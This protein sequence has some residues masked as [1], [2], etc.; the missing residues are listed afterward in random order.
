MPEGG[1][2][3]R[4]AFVLNQEFASLFCHF[5]IVMPKYRKRF[6]N[7]LYS[8]IPLKYEY[9][10]GYKQTNIGLILS[11]VLSRGKKIIFEFNETPGIE[12]RFIS[13]LGMDGIW[14][15][16]YN[17]NTA[18]IV[19]FGEK[20]AFYEEKRIG[21]NFSICY[22]RSKEWEYIFKD[23]GPDLMTDEVTWEVFY[24]A[25]KNPKMMNETF[26][27]FFM[28]QK[29]LAGVGNW[30]VAELAFK[31]RIRPTRKMQN[32]SDN[33]LW[34]AF[35]WVKKILWDSYNSGGLTIR[36]YVD[37]LGQIGAYETE[38]YGRDIDPYG[39]LIIKEDSKNGRKMH[40]SPTMQPY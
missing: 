27:E 33:D 37:P 4:V 11:R 30:V 14:S 6:G 1:E 13:G 19:K 18:I 23:V 10:N 12:G 35:T 31:C 8:S 16:T 26:Y 5:V 3:R 20:F 24:R 29:N 25:C 36:D 28:N 7:E 40:Y 22:F 32:L 9:K 34:N 21:G 17:S 39:N 38:C 2:V 15:L